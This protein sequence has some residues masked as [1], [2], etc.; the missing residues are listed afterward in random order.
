MNSKQTEIEAQCKGKQRVRRER[1]GSVV[2]INQSWQA[3]GRI[4]AFPH[5]ILQ[6]TFACLGLVPDHYPSLPLFER[7]HP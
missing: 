1:D 2:S 3:L 6:L 4:C 7:P 5:A